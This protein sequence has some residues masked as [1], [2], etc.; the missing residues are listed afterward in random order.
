MARLSAAHLRGRLL[1]LRRKAGV[2]RAARLLVSD[3]AQSPMVLG[4]ANPAIVMPRSLAQ[5][6]SEADFDH[7]ALHELAHLQRYDDWMNLLQKVIEALLPIQPAVIWI[8]RRL[9]PEREAACDDWV[10]A[11]T[12]T[13]RPY[14]TSLARIA[15]MTLGARCG[16]L[17]TGA[18]GRPS[19]LYRRVQRLLDRRQNATP[20]ILAVRTIAGVAAVMALAAAAI[21]A[22]PMIALADAAPEGGGIATTQPMARPE[23]GLVTKWENPSEYTETQA[24]AVKPGDK[25]VVDVHLGNVRVSTWDQNDVRILVRSKGAGVTEFLKHHH[26]TMSQHGAEVRVTAKTDFWH[27]SNSQQ[28]DVDYEIQTPKNFDADVKDGAG[29]M[30]VSGLDGTVVATTGA[31]NVL[32]A[33]TAGKFTVHSGAGNMQ[34][35]NT[36]G[37]VTLHTGAGNMDATQCAGALEMNTGAGNID[38]GQFAGDSAQ[39]KTGT[40]NVTAESLS[41]PKADCLFKTGMGNVTLKLVKTAAVTLDSSAGMGS[42]HSDFSGGQINGG[43]PILRL[44][45][46]MGDVQ[47]IRQ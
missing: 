22:P 36:A 9:G 7:I 19:Q 35:E 29:N 32:M 24:F 13:A 46:G 47:I 1:D 26:T 11:V 15:E 33:N 41:Q 30:D 17:A 31:G 40:G 39:A 10:V 43:G 18:I 2:I 5:G 3:E 45:S 44:K 21:Q 37:T 28:V 34:L 12:G 38:I 23:E 8:G 20:R 42:V 25:L 4:L 6:I 27:S 16:L 14:A